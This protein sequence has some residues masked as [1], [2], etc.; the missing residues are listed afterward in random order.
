MPTNAEP[1]YQLGMAYLAGAYLTFDDNSDRG[2]RRQGCIHG[3]ESKARL[4]W[5]QIWRE[6]SH[7][8]MGIYINQL[9][10]AEQEPHRQSNRGRQQ[11]FR[12]ILD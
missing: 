1:P 8:A 12:P 7:P 11:E 10:S 4:I 5:T 9:L 6:P 3:G 2:I